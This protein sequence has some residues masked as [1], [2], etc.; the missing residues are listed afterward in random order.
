[1]RVWIVN[2]FDTLPAEGHRP[3]R[4]W[5]MAEAFARAGH[6]TAYWT[7]DFNHVTKLPRSFGPDAGA[8]SGI[9]VV[10][11][12]E[13]PYRRNIGPGRLWAHW[14]WARNWR[15]AA[16]S[17]DGGAP[18]LIVVSTPPLSIGKEVRAFARKCAAKVVVDVMDAWPETFERVAP[19]WMLW[20]LRRLVRANYLGADAITTVADNYAE[21][22]RKYGFK[23]EVRRFYHGIAPGGGESS[24]RRGNGGVDGEIRL[25]YAGSMGRTYDL[26]TAIEAVGMMYGVRLELAGRGEQEE[27][28]RRMAQALPGDGASRVAFR[29][30]LG[31]RELADFLSSGDVGLVPMASESFVGVPYKLA[32]YARAGLAVASSLGGESGRMIAK[33][34]AGTAYRA[35]DPQSLAESIRRLAPRLAEAKSASRRMA[36]E[37]FDADRIYG[38]YVAFTESV[39]GASGKGGR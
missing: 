21:L 18:D 3:L 19:R 31:D 7:A 13:P 15:A 27:E 14:R 17:F 16:E 25:V 2:P 28:L 33:Y 9:R 8:A 1:M 11:V 26:K 34:G 20:P 30:Y 10:A 32:D 37:Q 6:E 23:G 24:D 35:G 4:F 39:C 5:L 38:E 22:V 36:S 29:G 12:H